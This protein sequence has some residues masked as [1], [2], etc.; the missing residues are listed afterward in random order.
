MPPLQHVEKTNRGPDPENENPI[1]VKRL[2]K[3]IVSRETV[4]RKKKWPDKT[5]MDESS[6]KKKSDGAQGSPAEDGGSHI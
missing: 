4:S 1:G 6:G 5:Y 3:E 2:A